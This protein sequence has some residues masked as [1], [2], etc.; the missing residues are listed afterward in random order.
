MNKRKLFPRS[1]VE[2]LYNFLFRFYT[3]VSSRSGQS[4]LEFWSRHTAQHS[5]FISIS[6]LPT[7]PEA[8]PGYSKQI[9]KSL[10]LHQVK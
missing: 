1:I 3:V 7:I 6:F 8:N 10:V 2:A 9:E 5:R 4:I